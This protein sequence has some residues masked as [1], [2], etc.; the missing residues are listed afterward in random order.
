MVLLA[1]AAGTPRTHQ[2]HQCA[3]L[4]ATDNDTAEQSWIRQLAT[5]MPF[6]KVAVAIANQVRQAWAMLAHRRLRPGRNTAVRKCIRHSNWRGH[7]LTQQSSNATTGCPSMPLRQGTKRLERIRV[8]LA[9]NLTPL[10]AKDL[11]S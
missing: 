1:H 7:L 4:V 8:N 6:G 10:D 9:D 5:R 11:S 2:H 3:M